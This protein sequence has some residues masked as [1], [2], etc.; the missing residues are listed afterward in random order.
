[1]ASL[2]MGDIDE[3]MNEAFVT[4]AFQAMGETVR[5]VKIIRNRFTG[6]L[7]GYCFVEFI[8]QATASRS[9]L[10][11]NGKAISGTN[12]PKRFKLKHALYTKPATATTTAAPAPAEVSP[13]PA[14]RNPAAEYVQA[15]N[16][17]TQQ[18]QQML[19]NWKYDPKSNAYSYQQYGY[20][21]N[22]WQSSEEFGEESMED[23]I[24][25]LDVNEANE[26]FM[27]QSEELYEALMDS[28][29]QPLDTVT[30]KIPL[31]V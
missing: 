10:N 14:V 25:Q 15:F 31:D 2:W 24:P 30:S 26:E 5:S 12:P 19:S 29:W 13:S 23:P 8:D 6:A 1:M 20:T 9:L 27:A 18:F 11:I 21:A 3:S 7:A 17:Y 16:Y 4:Q 28:H 22:T